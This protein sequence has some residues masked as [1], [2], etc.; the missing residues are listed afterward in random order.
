MTALAL[1]QAKMDTG[2]SM[3]RSGTGTKYKTNVVCS[4]QPGEKDTAGRNPF[5]ESPDCRPARHLK[6]QIYAAESY[7]GSTAGYLLSLKGVRKLAG[8][9]K[10]VIHAADG[11]IGRSMKCARGGAHPFKQRGARTVIE[12]YITYPFCVLNGST[13]HFYPTTVGVVKDHK[14]VWLNE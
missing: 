2:Y 3:Q 8:V 10:P 14:K 5:Q 9:Y 7:N 11:L 13:C 12:S 4:A 6:N 1:E